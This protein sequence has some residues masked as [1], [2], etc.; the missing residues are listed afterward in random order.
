MW[1]KVQVFGKDKNGAKVFA[2]S[3]GSYTTN[4]VN[5]NYVTNSFEIITIWIKR[6]SK[7]IFPPTLLILCRNKCI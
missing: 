3:L 1:P 2:L 4:D 7:R 5:K 6:T